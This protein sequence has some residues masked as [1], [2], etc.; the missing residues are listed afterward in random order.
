MQGGSSGPYGAPYAGASPFLPPMMPRIATGPVAQSGP[1]NYVSGPHGV[2]GPHGG[3]DQF[4]HQQQPQ[5]INRPGYHHQSLAF[6]APMPPSWGTRPGSSPQTTTP[7]PQ[8]ASSYLQSLVKC[9]EE[10]HSP[11][12]CSYELKEQ[13]RAAMSKLEQLK[14]IT[15]RIQQLSGNRCETGNHE[16]ST[17]EGM[18]WPTGSFAPDSSTSGSVDA[19]KDSRNIPAEAAHFVKQKGFE[20]AEP[21]SSETSERLE[22]LSLAGATAKALKASIEQLLGPLH[23]FR[24]GQGTRAETVAWKELGTRQ[25]K[26]KRYRGR[27]KKHRRQVAQK[28]REEREAFNSVDTAADEWRAQRLAQD[29]AR[30]RLQQMEK[31]ANAEAQEKKRQLEQ[32]VNSLL[33]LERLHKLRALRV[34]KLRRLGQIFPEE[35][36]DFMARVQ[37]SAQEEATEATASLGGTDEDTRYPMGPGLEGDVEPG[38]IVRSEKG[39]AE[40]HGLEQTRGDSAAIAGPDGS[41]QSESELQLYYLDSATDMGRLIQVRRAWDTFLSPDGSAIPGHWVAP[42]EPPGPAWAQFLERKGT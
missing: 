16:N 38:Q 10:R 20:P 19:L 15:Q 32:N 13:I 42:P 33:V 2:A 23:R 8:P 7:Q 3:V 14:E 26:I 9:I 5:W 1:F 24:T 31:A 36:D 21:K 28:L 37:Q 4:A 34:A 30:T 27:R 12:R 11:H 17:E 35:D 40:V 29:I 6:F 41:R 18:A 25:K 39:S 22:E